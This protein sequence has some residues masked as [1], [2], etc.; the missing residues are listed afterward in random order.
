MALL[1]EIWRHYFIFFISGRYLATL[2]NIL[3]KE[4]E[5]A[6]DGATASATA[7]VWKEESR[8]AGGR[9]RR[10]KS[11]GRKAYYYE[12]ELATTTSILHGMGV[13]E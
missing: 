8:R 3:G 13:S 4:G 12:R 10:E 11:G 1:G 9:R 5:S 2:K 6:L 7:A